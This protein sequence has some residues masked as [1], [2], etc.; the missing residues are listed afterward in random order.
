MMEMSTSLIRAEKKFQPWS[1]VVS[2]TVVKVEDT[3]PALG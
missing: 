2:Q 3:N 1:P